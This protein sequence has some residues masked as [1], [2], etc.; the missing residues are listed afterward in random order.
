MMEYSLL[1][2]CNHKQGLMVQRP[3]ASPGIPGQIVEVRLYL[4]VMIAF[5][6]SSLRQ[7]RIMHART[8]SSS[9]NSLKG[10]GIMTSA[11]AGKWF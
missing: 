8:G 4:G 1:S 9:S 2:R 10:S 11:R 6:E 7:S 3:T 5:M